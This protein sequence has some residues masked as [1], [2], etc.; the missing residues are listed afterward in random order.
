ML[1]HHFRRITSGRLATCHAQR[2]QPVHGHGRGANLPDSILIL[3][4][5]EAP[6]NGL[7]E[8]WR[9]YGGAGGSATNKV[10]VLMVTRTNSVQFIGDVHAVGHKP[11]GLKHRPEVGSDSSDPGRHPELAH[12][13]LYSA[14]VILAHELLDAV[15]LPARRHPRMFMKEVLPLLALVVV[16]V[17]AELHVPLCLLHSL[18]E[19]RHPLATVFI[20]KLI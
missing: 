15:E 5:G 8:S 10:N 1:V 11:G 12:M 17:D 7:A 6:A 14:H 2:H 19:S 20:H 3:L 16:H 13:S 9:I 4:R 18:L